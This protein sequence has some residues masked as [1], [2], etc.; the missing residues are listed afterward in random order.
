[1]I[2]DKKEGKD[3]DENLM[4]DMSD[5]DINALL[6]LD[7]VDFDQ[8]IR[9][10]HSDVKVGNGYSFSRIRSKFVAVQT[11]KSGGKILT[12]EKREEL[13]GLSSGLL[14]TS[15]VPHYL[16]DK[17]NPIDLESIKT[18]NLFVPSNIYTT[19]PA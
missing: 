9:S 5:L 3:I 8:N 17:A 10:V 13:S 11:Q 2:I 1:M 19:K 15:F 16:R 4:L 12:E 7:S 18:E 6:K 14:S